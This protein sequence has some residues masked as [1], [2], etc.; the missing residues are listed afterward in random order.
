MR[1]K[2]T[3]TN[4]EDKKPQGLRPI[5]LNSLF[6]IKLHK[7]TYQLYP[8]DLLF[9]NYNLIHIHNTTTP[10]YSLVDHSTTP[11]RLSSLTN[12]SKIQILE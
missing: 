8:K 12:N 3:L 9:N 5:N 1:H 4:Y 6:E 2:I 11:K 7:F 10:H